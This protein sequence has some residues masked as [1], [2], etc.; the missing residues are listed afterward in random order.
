AELFN[1]RFP[2]FALVNYESVIFAMCGPR[3]AWHF[4]EIYKLPVG[5]V[6]F[7]QSKVIAHSRRNIEA[8]AFVQI[9]LWPFVAEHVLPVIS[10]ERSSIFPLCIN[11][12]I[13]FANG[14][15]S[16]FARRDSRALVRVLKPGYNTWRFRPMAGA[17][18]IVVGK[19]A[20]EWILSRCE[21]YGNVIAATRRIRLRKVA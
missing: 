5:H 3:A 9:R 7:L 15:P 8:S 14:D 4:A 18:L 11:G 16:I 13:A 17:R 10:A 20:V 12:P 6:C 21:F 19:G 1:Q 2:L